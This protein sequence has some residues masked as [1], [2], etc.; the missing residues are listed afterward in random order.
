MF[1]H[2][3]GGGVATPEVLFINIAARVNEPLLPSEVEL[4]LL[5]LLLLVVSGSGTRDTG[6]W[7]RV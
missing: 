7:S 1:A 3:G 5:L 6:R 2:S 4:L